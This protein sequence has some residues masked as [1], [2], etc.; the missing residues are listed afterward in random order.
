MQVQFFLCNS[1]KRKIVAV[2][3]DSVYFRR[4]KTSGY[5]FYIY[6]IINPDTTLNSHDWL[7]HDICRNYKCYPLNDLNVNK[8][9]FGWDFTFFKDDRKSQNDICMSSMSAEAWLHLSKYTNYHLIF[10]IT[11]QYQQRSAYR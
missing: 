4:S 10:R 9:T 11:R 3:I 1:Y 2:L 7:L 6:K 5:I 8:T